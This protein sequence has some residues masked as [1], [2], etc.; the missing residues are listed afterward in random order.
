MGSF[1]LIRLQ[2]RSVVCE[3][4]LMDDEQTDTVKTIPEVI[5]SR[6]IAPL[7]LGDTNRRSESN[8]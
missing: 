8:L 7:F 2:L 4:K 6:S 3:R 1:I 5:L